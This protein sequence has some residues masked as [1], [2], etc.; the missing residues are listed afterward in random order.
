[1]K[2][3]KTGRCKYFNYQ[4][5]DQFK[6]F[7]SKSNNIQVVYNIF[8]NVYSYKINFYYAFNFTSTYRTNVNTDCT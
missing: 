4:E 2:Y 3:F 7:S 8:R 1:M 6:I 5:S